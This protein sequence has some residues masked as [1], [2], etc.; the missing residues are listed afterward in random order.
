MTA[1]HRDA[2]SDF[3]VLPTIESL[4]SNDPDWVE[5]EAE[6]FPRYRDLCRAF[7]RNLL[8]KADLTTISNEA[9]SAQNLVRIGRPHIRKKS[10]VMAWL[11]ENWPSV[12]E[13]IRQNQVHLP[14]RK[15]PKP[16]RSAAIRKITRARQKAWILGA[17]MQSQ[18]SSRL[19][20]DSVEPVSFQAKSNDDAGP[21]PEG[22]DWPDFGDF[23]ED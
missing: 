15:W 10:G 11:Q 6:N 23:H 18:E 20:V 21:G 5:Q 13:A 16:V 4:D 22:D 12:E 8:T 14:E 1:I 2:S 3:P 17:F 9:A 19:P 7:G